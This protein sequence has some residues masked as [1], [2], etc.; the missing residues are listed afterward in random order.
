MILTKSSTV[1]AGCQSPFSKFAFG[2]I[3]ES[4][5]FEITPFH[6]QNNFI[7]KAKLILNKKVL[8]WALH[9]HYI[10]S[11]L[12]AKVSKITHHPM[13][14]LVNFEIEGTCI[15]QSLPD[16]INEFCLAVFWYR[17]LWAGLFGSFSE[18]W[19]NTRGRL[20]LLT[21]IRGVIRKFTENSCHFYIVWSM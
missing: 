3:C 11:L 2:T 5:L 4:G 19:K 6:T 17:Y 20:E 13:Q 8:K 7:S 14:I 12:L 18:N 1:H 15:R 10:D 9:L 21:S 16:T